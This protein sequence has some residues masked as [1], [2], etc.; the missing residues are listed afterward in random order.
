MRLYQGDARTLKIPNTGSCYVVWT[1]NYFTQMAGRALILL[2]LLLMVVVVVVVVVL[3]W[4]IYITAE[5]RELSLKLWKYYQNLFTGLV[6]T[7]WSHNHHSISFWEM[8]KQNFQHT[9]LSKKRVHGCFL[10]YVLI[11]ILTF[12]DI[13]KYLLCIRNIIS[14][15]KNDWAIWFFWKAQT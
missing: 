15:V 11:Y 12:K 9:V 3:F 8:G 1:Q 6:I 7:I 13:H 5:S 2:L 10:F 14:H 4:D